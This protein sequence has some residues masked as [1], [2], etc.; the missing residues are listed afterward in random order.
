MTKTAA[1]GQ[2]LPNVHDHDSTDMP[3]PRRKAMNNQPKPS[4]SDDKRP[5]YHGQQHPGPFAAPTPSTPSTSASMTAH[6]PRV[7]AAMSWQQSHFDSGFQS[8]TP[9]GAPSVMS[10][11]SSE[12]SMN[13]AMTDVPPTN[14]SEQSLARIER[15]RAFFTGSDPV[16]SKEA[17]PELI[18]LLDDSDEE[19]VEKSIDLLKNMARSDNWRPPEAP[20][21]IE[22]GDLVFAVKQA[23]LR[24]SKNKYIVRCCMCIFFFTSTEVTLV[25]LIKQ[26][27]EELL[28][29]FINGIIVTEY[30]TYKYAYLVLHSLLLNKEVGPS[31]VQYIRDAKALNYITHWLGEPVVKD[32]LLSIVVDTIYIIC[33]RNEEQRSFF[34]TNL[35]GIPKL[36][37][38][39][40]NR[41]YIP[42]ITNVIRLLQSIA[43]SDNEKAIYSTRIVNAGCLN[44]VPRFLGIPEARSLVNV[45]RL[46]CDLSDIRPNGD[47]T[48]LLQHLINLIG[49][50]DF[51]VKKTT[52]ECIRNLIA[53]Q[54][55][56]KEFVVNHGIVNVLVHL[57][58]ETNER[59]G[60]DP[61]CIEQIQE[62]TIGAL[63]HLCWNHPQSEATITLLLQTPLPFILLK[64]L[65]E[66]R[67]G[68]LKP[69]LILLSRLAAN[70]KNVAILRTIN[71]MLNGRQHWIVPEVCAVLSVAF[72]QIGVTVE[73]VKIHTLARAALDTLSNFAKDKTMT[74]AVYGCLAEKAIPLT[75]VQLLKFE[76]PNIDLNAAKIS[77]LKLLTELA[78]C[79]IGAKYL[80]ECEF[81][82]EVLQQLAPIDIYSQLV[83]TIYDRV[84]KTQ[85]LSM[86]PAIPSIPPPAYHYPEPSASTY[87]NPIPNQAYPTNTN[88]GYPP[89]DMYGYPAPGMPMSGYDSQVMSIGEPKHEDL[90]YM[91]P[92]EEHQYPN[93]QPGP[94]GPIPTATVPNL[95]PPNQMPMDTSNE[96]GMMA[97][98][99][100]P[101]EPMHWS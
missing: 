37:Q 14:L 19:V 31:V 32:K 81:T 43:A 34:V 98:G 29:S 69:T 23:M 74:E 40:T 51:I 65:T 33:H 73:D 54:A 5:P 18:K 35:D 2:D 4:T 26:Y 13:S 12:M 47:V 83:K 6:N 20:A 52:V 48:V 86:P 91:T 42:L 28:D 63:S 15:V 79:P 45:L 87:A 10:F 55:Q 95:V 36:V 93:Y 46:V 89:P 72:S 56:C 68:V 50:P 66:L 38:I 62:S 8:M 94:Q 70:P 67:P 100:S 11:A 53:N 64:K 71:I 22:K 90:A 82:S 97:P 3:M 24:Y 30:A 9:S 58:V 25:P 80:S 39:L 101:Y 21:V 77:A 1:K 44:V 96:Y 16:K 85:S 84:N 27:K 7:S 17:L 88:A 57:M 92:I 49:F 59:G 76:L 78:G 99:P 60:A 41:G 61:R 75:P